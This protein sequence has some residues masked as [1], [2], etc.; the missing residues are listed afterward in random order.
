MTASKSRVKLRQTLLEAD[1]HILYELSFL[2]LFEFIV[3]ASL[4]QY[5]KR[6]GYKY[7][8]FACVAMLL[9]ILR[10]V[11]MHI[12]PFVPDVGWL[13]SLEHS[14]HLG[15]AAFVLL[16][17]ATMLSKPL[18]LKLCLVALVGFSVF[19]IGSMQAFN[20]AKELGWI[21]TLVPSSMLLVLAAYWLIANRREGFVGVFW[22]SGLI[23]MHVGLNVICSSFVHAPDTEALIVDLN[24]YVVLLQGVS[25]LI[26][27]SEV[28]IRDLDRRDD[29]IEAYAQEQKR[30]EL[31]FSHA[32]KLES[33]GL[34]AAG[35]AHDFNN[36]LTSILGYASLAMKKS[37]VESEAR[38]DLY[39]V[40]SGA[41]QAVDLTSQ[42]LLYAGKGALEF[43][44]INLTN[45][46]DGMKSLIQ[47]A[48]PKKVSLNLQLATSLPNLKGDKAQVGQVVM[49]LVTNAV[50]AIEDKE[51]HIEILTGL[52][53]VDE[54]LL[55]KCLMAEE[56]K[57]GAYVFV[58]VRDSGVG[59]E[60]KMIDRIFDPF[61]S[62][63]STNKGLGLSS[64]SGI[65]RQHNGFVRVRTSPRKGSEF[66]VY[67]PQVTAEDTA[68]LRVVAGSGVTRTNKGKILL[69]DDDQRIR[70]LMV[71]I[72]ESDRYGV[73][74][75]PDGR[76]ALRKFAEHQ[77][78]FDALIL[79]C[80]MPKMS[81]V[82]VYREVRQ[83][84]QRTPV[85]LVSGYHQEQVIDNIID[86]Q[87]AYFIKKPFD[88]DEFLSLVNDAINQ[89]S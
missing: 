75:A 47:S 51:G 73:I 55:S 38:Q 64:L 63:K 19:G 37:P 32:Q 29:Q 60:P 1:M 36:M 40:I 4:W 35:I 82:E 6:T 71:S 69:A 80:T 57:P 18:P 17:V 68:R 2:M 8:R 56:A 61:F 62:V 3:V 39:M 45:S 70:S 26:I 72:L 89:S 86:D 48:L 85:I 76:E 9:E 42:M 78:Y 11:T 34:L 44:S 81:G 59:M 88:V 66:T 23:V 28:L 25:F 24:A 53:R 67:F 83:T 54:D 21:A 33:L 84:D 30:L 65:V 14:L 46:I 79:D 58:T 49:N 27:T 41:R 15:F 31:Q 77:D 20:F 7:F 5:H 74:S 22:L 87:R 52:A 10:Q 16:A 50:D 13:G 12:A 43:E